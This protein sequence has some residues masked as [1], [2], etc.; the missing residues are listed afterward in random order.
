MFHF[1]DIIDIAILTLFTCIK[2]TV[3]SNPFLFWYNF[4]GQQNASYELTS[5]VKTLHDWLTVLT[6]DGLAPNAAGDRHVAGQQHAH[7]L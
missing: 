5:D 1:L 6:L 4:S 3:F 2:K 7:K